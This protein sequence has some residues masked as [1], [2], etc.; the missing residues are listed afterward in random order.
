MSDFK[1]RPIRSKEDLR[2]TLVVI[3]EL[4]DAEPGTNLYDRLDLL[5]T[6]VEAYEDEVLTDR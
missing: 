4:W 3:E 5:T 2:A 6:L 1:L